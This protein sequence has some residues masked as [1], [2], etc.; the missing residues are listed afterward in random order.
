MTTPDLLRSIRVALETH[1]DGAAFRAEVKR[2][3]DEHDTPPM[4]PEMTHEQYRAKRAEIEAR[5]REPI[6]DTAARLFKNPPEKGS[7]GFD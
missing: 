1:R 5:G 4:F 6:E 3:L 2:L 7:F